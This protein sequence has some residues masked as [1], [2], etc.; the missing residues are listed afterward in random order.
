VAEI[1]NPTLG[2]FEGRRVQ[3]DGRYIIDDVC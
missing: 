3:F 2:E 1:G